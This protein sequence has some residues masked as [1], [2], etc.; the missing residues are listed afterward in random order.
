MHK[1]LFQFVIHFV[2]LFHIVT[3]FEK[4]HKAVI[5]L[6]VGTSGLNQQ[7]ELVNLSY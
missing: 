7:V 6:G 2:M 1:V 5:T 3:Q 4:E